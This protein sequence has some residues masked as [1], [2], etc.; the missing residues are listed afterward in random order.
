MT[1]LASTMVSRWLPT[2][3]HV[4]FVEFL[5][6]DLA[7]AANSITTMTISSPEILA[8]VMDSHPPS[9]I[10]TDSDFLSHIIEQ[11]FDLNQHNHTTVIVVGDPGN[12]GA[13]LAGEIDLLRFVDIER[14]G[15]VNPGHLSLPT[16]EPRI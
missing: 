1:E 6:A 13:K 15:A 11:V 10:I 8:S 3:S 14:E 2:N 4:I 9:A 12:V 5:I 16:G 7:F